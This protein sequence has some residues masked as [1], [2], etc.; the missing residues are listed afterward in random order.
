VSWVSSVVVFI[1]AWWTV[2]FAILPW[3]S[4]PP[5]A[6]EA[7][8]EPGAPA[9]PRLALK[10]AVTTALAAAIWAVVFTLVEL[11]VFSFRDWART[12]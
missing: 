10:F 6:P 9:R 1:L 11:D 4:H 5:E 12:L 8:H 3:G 2:L 7:G